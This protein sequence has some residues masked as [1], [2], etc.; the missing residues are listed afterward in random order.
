MAKK[1]P[2]CYRA[3]RNN[4]QGV[5]YVGGAGA[6]GMDGLMSAESECAFCLSVGGEHSRACPIQRERGF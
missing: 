4:P 2:H 1:T 3:G 6:A 5:S